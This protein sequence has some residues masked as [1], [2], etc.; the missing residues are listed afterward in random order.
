MGGWLMDTPIAFNCKKC[1]E[2]IQSNTNRADGK[3]ICPK[4]GYK[5]VPPE[6][7]TPAGS[8]TILVKDIYHGD[9]VTFVGSMSILQTNGMP[10]NLLNTPIFCI[11]TLIWFPSWY[12][13]TTAQ[14]FRSWMRF[15]SNRIAFLM[16]FIPLSIP[17]KLIMGAS[18]TAVLPFFI[19]SYFNCLPKCI[20]W[21]LLIEESIPYV[22]IQY[23]CHTG[24]RHPQQRINYWNLSH[25][26]QR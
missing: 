22:V 5:N 8:V 25:E 10:T 24:Q 7:Y 21:F 6:H 14:V 12:H 11:L 20:M 26:I 19:Q 13:S 9:W 1:G 15:M 4:C 18:L 17:V 23:D 2:P 16:V 3:V